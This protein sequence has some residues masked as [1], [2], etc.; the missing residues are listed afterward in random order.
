[1]SAGSGWVSLETWQDEHDK[2]VAAEARIAKAMRLVTNGWPC[3]AEPPHCRPE[4]DLCSWETVMTN[5]LT[6]RIKP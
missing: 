4:C 3:P 6:E 2:V 1:M 5:A